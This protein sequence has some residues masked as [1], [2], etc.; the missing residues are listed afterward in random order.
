MKV[1]KW[2]VLGIA[3]A[4]V[5]GYV[6]SSD[7]AQIKVSDD[8]FADLGYWMKV[9]YVNFDE[10][11]EE[12]AGIDWSTNVFDVVDAR[13]NIEGQIAK[14]VQFYGEIVTSGAYASGVYDTLA[15]LGLRTGRDNTARLSEG[16]INLVFL[17][18]LQLRLGKI[19]IPFTRDQQEARYSYIIQSDWIYDAHGL[20]GYWRNGLLRLF[21]GG[22]NL[23]GEIAGGMLRYD[24]GIFNE[25]SS[26]EPLEDVAWAVRLEF[27]PTMLGF[28][29]ETKTTGRG[30]LHDTHLGKKGDILSIGLSYFTQDV[31]ID[32]LGGVPVIWAYYFGG[33]FGGALLPGIG[34]GPSN[35]SKEL[36]VDAYNV[37]IFLE[38]KLGSTLINLEGAYTYFN[39]SHLTIKSGGSYKTEDSYFWYLQGQIMYDGVVGLG[40]PALYAKY[41]YLEA[42]GPVGGLE[43]NRWAVG[44]NYYIV[45][46]AARLTVGVDNVN[47][48]EAAS[49]Y[50]EGIG[51]EDNITD[52]YVQA[53]IMF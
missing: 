48:D 25:A 29:P 7:A 9:R 23:H 32:I 11:A 13:F 44:V 37:D 24:L 51:Y 16:G 10:R 43:M 52:I 22:A 39:D 14:P 3:G 20:F 2:K 45:G 19:R 6:V 36:D 38:K 26:D 47:Y 33:V 40:K 53:Q 42:D 18:E 50:L 28:K 21:D 31:N 12:G 8:T 41:E 4:L 35:Y 30:W 46:N 17:P 34:L 27:T 5:L 49:D 15:S 1:S